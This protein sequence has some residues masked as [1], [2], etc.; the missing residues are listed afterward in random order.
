MIDIDLLKSDK[1]EITLSAKS[2]ILWSKSNQNPSKNWGWHVAIANGSIANVNSKGE[3][4]QPGL[5]SL[6]PVILIG[7][8]RISICHYF[9]VWIFI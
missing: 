5:Q 3:S 7:F 1:N 8:G 9:S 6:L 2:D 4:E